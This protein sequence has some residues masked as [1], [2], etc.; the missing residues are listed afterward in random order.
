MN[1]IVNGVDPEIWDPATDEHL[2]GNNYTADE[3]FG[4][5]KCKIELQTAVKL[6]ILPDT[7]LIG[8]VGRLDLQKGPEI[9]LSAV[10][11]ICARGCQVVMLGSGDPG[12]EKWVR[13]T[14]VSEWMVL[15]WLRHRQAARSWVRHGGELVY[16]LME[17]QPKGG[18]VLEDFGASEH[19]QLFFAGAL[20]FAISGNRGL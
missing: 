6:D 7:P 15:D 2:D 18:P 17:S 3:M 10:P 20:P 8:W 4:K 11:D 5:L 19:R 13:E 9:L 1:G 16:L 12:I 14:Q